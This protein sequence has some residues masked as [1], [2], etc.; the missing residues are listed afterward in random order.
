M[1]QGACFGQLAVG[2]CPGAASILGSGAAGKPGRRSPRRPLPPPL[3]QASSPTSL[4][5]MQ[6]LSS[7]VAVAQ[8]PAC[9]APRQVRVGWAAQNAHSRC[10]GPSR[11]APAPGAAPAPAIAAVSPTAGSHAPSPPPPRRHRALQ[12]RQAGAFKV[13]A[14]KVTLKTPSGTQVRRGG[15]CRARRAPTLPPR[16]AMVLPGSPQP[17]APGASRPA[18]E[19]HHPQSARPQPHPPA[20]PA[21]RR[22][23]SAPRTPTSWTPRR[24]PVSWCSR[25]TSGWRQAGRRRGHAPR[26]STSRSRSWGAVQHAMATTGGA[27]HGSHAQRERGSGGGDGGR[28]SLYHAAAGAAWAAARCSLQAPADGSCRSPAAVHPAGRR[29]PPCPSRR[30]PPCTQASTCPTRAARAPAPAAPA[31]LRPVALTRATSPSWTTTRWARALCWCAAGCTSVCARGGALR[32]CVQGAETPALGVELAA[33]ACGMR[34][35]ERGAAAMQAIGSAVHSLEPPPPLPP[36]SLTFGPDSPL[37]SPCRPAWLT[38][39]A[40]AP[41]PPTRLVGH[42]AEGSGA[43]VGQ[44]AG[45]GPRLPPAPRLRRLSEDAP[46]PALAPLFALQPAGRVPVLSGVL[47]RHFDLRHSDAAAAP[48]RCSQRG[49]ACGRPP[50]FTAHL[51]SCPRGPLV[52]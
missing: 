43:P 49:R 29:N 2:R 13:Q 23:S 30:A 27:R 40:T 10:Q 42:R 31:R 12:A 34:C 51:P 7:K 3:L 9:I 16:D 37:V 24:R 6:A 11:P 33:Q 38:P 32:A 50:P 14:Y 46:L 39:P 35:A 25:R 8:R 45:W 52:C 20:P 44:Q 41:S 17:H 19:P 48:A 15:A 4:A 22:P 18:L 26:C 5:A 28:R 1:H 47:D 36:G 21:T